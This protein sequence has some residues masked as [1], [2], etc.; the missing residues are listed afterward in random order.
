M[1]DT[2]LPSLLPLDIIW[3]LRPEEGFSGPEI[4]SEFFLADVDAE[5]VEY[6]E[7]VVERNWG[8]GV[9]VRVIPGKWMNQCTNQSFRKSNFEGALILDPASDIAGNRRAVVSS[10]D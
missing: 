10:R 8:V 6:F 5:M 3:L 7:H 1:I 2:V 9:V 4:F